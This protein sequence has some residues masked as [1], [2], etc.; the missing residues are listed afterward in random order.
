MLDDGTGDIYHDVAQAPGFGGESGYDEATMLRFFAER[1]GDPDRAGQA[2]AARPDAV[3]RRAAGRAVLARPARARPAARA[4]T[5]SAP[6]SRWT[7][8]AWASTCRAAAATWSSRTT[9]TPP[10]TP[11]RSPATKP[12]A[13]AYVHAAMIGLDGEKMSKSRGNLVFVSRLRGDGVDPMAIR[14]ALLSGHYRTDRAWT[15]DLLSAAAG[16]AGHLA[17]GGGPGRRRARGAAAARA[18]ASGWPTTSTAPA[19]SRW[20][21]PGPRATLA[22]D[23]G[24]RGRGAADRLRRRRRAARCGAGGLR[25]TARAVPVHR[26]GR[27]RG[28]PRSSS[29]RRRPARPDSRG[30]ARPEPEDPLRTAFERDRDRILHAKAFRRLK[31]KTQVFLNPDGDHFVTRLTHT[32]Q[33]T[34]VARSLARALGLNETLAEAIA[35]AHDVGHSPF[36][37]LGEDALEPYVPGGWHHAA[38]GVRIVEVLEHLNLTWE[39]RDGVRAHSWKID[40][41]PATR[42]G[43]CVRYADRI[44]YL[45]HD[46]LDA[47]PRRGAA[48]RRPAGPRPRG[49][50]RAGQ[51][52]GR[53]DDRRRRRGQ[54]RR[55]RTPPAPS[56]WRPSRSRRCTSCA[57]FMF[58]RVY[59]SD[60]AAGQKHVAIDVIRRLVDHHLAHPEL[61]PA[62]YRDTEADEVTQVVDYV[63]G[64][65]D[66]FALNMHDRLFDADA[67]SRDDAACSRATAAGSAPV[68]ERARPAR[69]SAT[70]ATQRLSVLRGTAPWPALRVRQARASARGAAA[71]EVA[72]ELAGDLVAVGLG[73]VDLGGPL[74]ERAHVLDD[75]V[76]LVGHLVDGLDPVVGLLRQRAER[77][78]QLEDLLDP[79]QQR[80]GGPRRRRLRDVVR[81]G[82]PEADRRQPGLHAGVLEDAEDP[83]R[84]LVAG[85]LQAVGRAR[86][87]RRRPSR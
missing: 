63:S 41:P 22:G 10:C 38:Q 47:D 34:Q 86:T 69:V 66:R 15:A 76:V 65:T 53:H 51:R 80:H 87:R 57:T 11:R 67:T 52:D 60:T 17:A 64:M 73:Q 2:A 12:F 48:A 39:V 33:V 85:G 49:V 1:G 75:L 23:A 79:L 37:H 21:T 19:R 59:M 26:P 83:G 36:G 84:A 24:R 18:C 14:L 5:S 13:R 9:S 82:G 74:L 8:S 3:A 62:T 78:G 4:G 35:L 70:R 50:R 29:R 6:R 54:P 28:A 72:L 30:R 7:P 46:A 81:H 25:M 68:A 71:A 27:P 58:E 55:R 43:E 16:A 20:S 40:P 61:I 45:S 32:L 56:S 31:H 77:H 42:E 44:G